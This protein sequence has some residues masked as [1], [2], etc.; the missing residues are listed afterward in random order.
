M[1]YSNEELVDMVY[2]IGECQRNCLLASRVYRERYPERRHPQQ[3]CFERVKARFERSANANYE[4]TLRIHEVSNENNQFDV[5]AAVV[6]NPHVSVRELSTEFNVSKSL[7]H[8]ILLK[9][10]F[11]PYHIQLQQH[12][13][14][15]DFQLR[16]NFCNWAHG[17]DNN[18]PNF[19]NYVLFSDEA[20]F[21]N[22][23]LVNHHNFHFYDNKNP[24]FI[25]RIDSQHRFNVNVWG[26]IVGSNVIG[27]YFLDGNLNGE[28][29]LDFLN[30]QLEDLLEDVPL[31]VVRRVWFMHDGAPAH[32]SERVRQFLNNNYGNQWIGRGGPVLWP[33]RS[34]DLNPMDF[35]LWG[36]TKN[37]VYKIIPTSEND[38]KEKIR[39]AFRSITPLM[40]S[41][42]RASF[43]K[44]VDTCLQLNG[45]HFEH[46]L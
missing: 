5:V 29:Y 34:P 6:E 1:N 15:Q 24:H 44:R 45:H 35:F 4:K 23:G 18:D 30:R 27:P 46:V 40:L 19:F 41:N 32:Y 25:R 17:K 8:K 9:H 21:S 22:T 3:Q 7:A 26:G 42:V 11:H 13:T 33:P 38:L 31:D 2:L 12:L 39:N 14:E 43:R 28:K 10:K 36:Y 16:L 37:L 20:S